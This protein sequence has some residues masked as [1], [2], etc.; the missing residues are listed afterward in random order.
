MGVFIGKRNCPYSVFQMLGMSLSW[1]WNVLVSLVRS[2]MPVCWGSGDRLNPNTH[3]SAVGTDSVADAASSVKMWRSQSTG[4]LWFTFLCLGHSW[5]F[6]DKRYQP[7]YMGMGIKS[8]ATFPGTSWCWCWP[9]SKEG[10]RG[11]KRKASREK[12]NIALRAKS[13]VC[14]HKPS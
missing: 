4:G 10:W 13:S 3:I 11:M 2:E 1:P 6:P 12:E 14:W 5:R 9:C 8:P 7:G